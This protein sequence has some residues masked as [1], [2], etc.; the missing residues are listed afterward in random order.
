MIDRYALPQMKA[1][2]SEENKFWSWLRVEL[3]ACEAWARLGRIP[4]PALKIIKE[5]AD[6]DLNRINEIE[7][8]TRHDLIAFVTS[9]REAVGEDGK[10]IHLGLT[11]YDIEDT[12]LSL[13]MRQALDIIS[14]DIK[15]LSLVLRKK[16]LRHKNTVMVGRTHGMHAQPIT[17][18][19]KLALCL[20]EMRRNAQR[21][22]EARRVIN[23][24]KLSGAVGT[25]AYCPPE[26]EKYV[27]RK[28]KLSTPEVSTQILQ[29]DRHAHF[30]TTLAIVAGSLEK[31]ATEIRNLQRTEIGEVEEPFARGQKGSSAMPH[32]RNPIISERICG[33]SRLLRSNALAGLE[34]ISLWHE[35]DLSNS[36]LERIII[37][38]SSILLDYILQKFTGVIDGLAVNAG[39]M[40]QNLEM[41]R[42]LIFSQGIMLAL[43]EKGA[44]SEE[45]Y[46]MVQGR[47]TETQ[48][49]GVHLKKV[50]LSDKEV[51]K[52]LTKSEIAAC[53]DTK[54]LLRNVEEIFKKI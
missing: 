18:G 14:K 31:Y 20:S 48:K 35:R 51:K 27:C 7:K 40:K 34:T 44:S 39:K 26:V 17:F 46:R 42:G 45:A 3:L 6:F 54:Y 37:P 32:K 43:S 1:L 36:S 41:S 47:A 2:W 12:A 52:Y 21:I 15:R 10:Y 5:K 49:T 50:L 24:G 38:D 29:R 28:L 22:K 4:S 9:V 8:R 19:L 16:A 33:L 13:R 25:Y 11:S 30:L 53:F 23:Y